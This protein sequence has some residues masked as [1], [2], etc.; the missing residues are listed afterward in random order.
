MIVRALVPLVVLGAC[1]AP[2][3]P[4]DG[5]I[6]VSWQAFDK[7]STLRFEPNGRV[8]TTNPAESITAPPGGYR[9]FADLLE[10][11][12]SYANGDVPCLKPLSGELGPAM[13][14]P[15]IATIRWE[16]T[17]QS[18]RIDL[19]CMQQVE[20]FTS[21][22]NALDLVRGWGR[23]PEPLATPPSEPDIDVNKTD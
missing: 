1:S 21:V 3:A 23:T 5:T 14:T 2:A 4:R 8:S 22:K 13:G 16:A 18:V 15:T 6:S 9:Q 10:A 12:R 7:A 20:P 11:A 17:G 19:T